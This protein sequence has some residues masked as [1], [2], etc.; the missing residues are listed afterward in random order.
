MDIKHLDLKALD[1]LLGAAERERQRRRQRRPAHEVRAL[2][3]ASAAEAGYRLADVFPEFPI[4]AI[5]AEPAPATSPAD[6]PSAHSTGAAVPSVAAVVADA[7]PAD[8]R[9]VAREIARALVGVP[10]ADVLAVELRT[11]QATLGLDAQWP[12]FHAGMEEAS[13]R[14]WVHF[15]GNDRCVL[16]DEG[17][18]AAAQPLVAETRGS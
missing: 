4:P 3:H 2:L 18:R 5:P 14:N 9:S 11:L 17:A 7:R 10:H 12:L 6:T 15:R 13:R 1:R 8:A 16:T